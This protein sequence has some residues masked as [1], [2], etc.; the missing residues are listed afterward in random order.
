MRGNEL[1]GP[2]PRSIAYETPAIRGAWIAKSSPMK[3]LLSR[4]QIGLPPN[5]DYVASKLRNNFF[6]KK[7]LR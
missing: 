4:R 5:L 2:H 1:N 7:L 6:A 3:Y